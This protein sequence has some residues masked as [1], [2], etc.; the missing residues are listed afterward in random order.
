MSAGGISYSGLTTNRKVTLP[1]VDMWG[2]DMNILRNPLRSVM[3]R[4]VDKVGDTQNILLEQDASGDRIA[5][6]I[7]VYAR[8]VNPMVSVS[9][10][11]ASNN[12]G[13]LKANIKGIGQ[14]SLPY[15][16]Q[17]VRP[18]LFRQE[19]LTPLSRLPRVWCHADTNPQYPN[20]KDD[21]TCSQIQR[22]IHSDDTMLRSSDIHAGCFNNTTPTLTDDAIIRSLQDSKPIVS[23]VLKSSF[24]TMKSAGGGEKDQTDIFGEM[25]EPIGMVH[26]ELLHPDISSSKGSD[27]RG[28]TLSSMIL[29]TSD[30]K[31]Q[32]S[33]DKNKQIYEAFSFLGNPSLIQHQGD[34][35]GQVDLQRHVHDQL[36]WMETRS[37]PS[38]S[39]QFHDMPWER[40]HK[41]TQGNIHHT[42]PINT[43]MSLPTSFEKEDRNIENKFLAP[44]ID[45]PTHISIKTQ[46]YASELRKDDRMTD[47]ITSKNVILTEPMTIPMYSSKSDSLRFTQPSSSSSI[48]TRPMVRS[49][50]MN[51]STQTAHS[52]PSWGEG[53]LLQGNENIV[54]HG[55]HHRPLHL[56]I[57]S[58]KQGT[59]QE[60]DVHPLQHSSVMIQERTLPNYEWKST[61]QS[62]FQKEL[63]TDIYGESPIIEQ[64]HN[65][66]TPILNIQSAK[67]QTHLQGPN[68][69]GQREIMSQRLADRPVSQ[70]AFLNNQA[71]IPR[72][73]HFG[74]LSESTSPM[75][76]VP[77]VRNSWKHTKQQA[78]QDYHERNI[79]IRA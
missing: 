38:V 31:H 42:S 3:T 11:N 46:K 78:F 22:T 69:Y 7:L 47:Q 37:N 61:P 50:M 28:S 64:P 10:D 19:D 24:N 73:Q 68:V 53:H 41:S 65:R 72:N 27:Q 77:I 63:V 60:S 34:R 21:R 5:E 30:G 55:V 58:S 67:Q 13:S 1:S 14:T 12:A 25:V 62:S 9:Y 16:V 45:S 54:Q 75:G 51:I 39:T 15:K 70:S 48:D 57:E 4:R 66:S 17:N 20:F 43:V 52:L 44:V 32:K 56:S 49:D 23:D 6:N 29:D 36:L 76:S 35:Q 79:Q 59:T 2:S 26:S 8:G 74:Q 71:S 18:P 33:I 40:I